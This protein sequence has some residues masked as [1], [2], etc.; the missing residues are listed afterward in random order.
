M[1]SLKRISVIIPASNEQGP[2]ARAL[3]SVYAQL[4]SPH[5]VIVVINGSTDRT[6]EVAKNY[7][8]KTL[9]FDEQ[10]GSAR[11]RNE[12]AKI[13]TGDTLV[14][15]DADS[16]MENNVLA[17][18]AHT[19]T[20]NTFG[21]VRGAP[22]T[23]ALQYRL[24][25][26]WKNAIHYLRLFR[27]VLGGL[28]F[29]DATLFRSIHGY[30]ER[31]K[32]NE[33]ADIISRAG[34]HGG[35]YRYLPKCTSRTSMRRF[36]ERGLV[37]TFFFWVF[38]HIFWRSEKHRER[39]GSAYASSHDRLFAIDA[40]KFGASVVSLFLGATGT[41]FGSL[42]LFASYYGP[43]A[44]VQ[45]VFAEEIASD[46]STP[47]I[48]TMLYVAA[49]SRLYTLAFFGALILLVSALVLIKSLRNTRDL[50]HAELSL[51]PSQGGI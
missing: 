12:G 9:V 23:Q 49:V 11:A 21:T 43:T 13:A 22:D 25:F 45:E 8:A 19:E 14:F 18:I 1:D 31:L 47:I 44:F 30:D 10:L 27:G 33:H 16:W 42:V 17:T 51:E 41:I 7:G 39:L 48:D 40:K 6:A 5:E 4:Y 28:L 26:V 2:I 50:L 24:F 35:T 37:E 15:L 3:N 34:K 32:V 46:P 29:F 38:L 20:R 36:E